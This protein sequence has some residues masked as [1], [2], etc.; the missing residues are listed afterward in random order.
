VADLFYCQN[1]IKFFSKWQ[2]KEDQPV[3]VEEALAAVEGAVGVVP[4]GEGEGSLRTKMYAPVI[5]T[6][7]EL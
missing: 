1:S 4:G 7:Y 3:V 6:L 5:I 2:T